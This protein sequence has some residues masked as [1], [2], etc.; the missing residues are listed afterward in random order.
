MTG[1]KLVLTSS[2]DGSFKLWD[3]KKKFMVFNSSVKNF[4]RDE[5]LRSGIVGRLFSF[6]RL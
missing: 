5:K 1:L 4:T 6:H 2:M 3:V